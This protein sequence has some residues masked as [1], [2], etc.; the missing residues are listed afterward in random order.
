MAQFMLNVRYF[1]HKESN[2]GRMIHARCSW[3]ILHEALG[4]SRATVNLIKMRDDV[5]EFLNPPI[6]ESQECLP[7]F[8]FETFSVRC[9]VLCLDLAVSKKVEQYFDFYA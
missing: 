9:E 7:L 6:N 8:W 1:L 4:L 2:Q 3:N 5:D